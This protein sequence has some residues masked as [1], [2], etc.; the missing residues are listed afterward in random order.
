VKSVGW[1]EG[2]EIDER[3]AKE[4]VAF[5]YKVFFT[6]YP[7]TAFAVQKKRQSYLPVPRT[8]FRGYYDYLLTTMLIQIF[9]SHS[10]FHAKELHSIY[11]VSGMQIQMF[12]L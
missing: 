3:A 7:A 1:R 10:P 11:N 4:S 12:A 8:H 9:C 5:G 6:T 2:L